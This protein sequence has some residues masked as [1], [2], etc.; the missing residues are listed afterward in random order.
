M[1]K[2]IS[3]LRSAEERFRALLNKRDEINA[4]A[5]ATRAERDTLNDRKKELQEQM[6]D[7]RDKRDA[8][9]A[10]MR[11]FKVRRDEFQRKAKELIAFK[12]SLRGRPLGDLN[13]EIRNLSREIGKMDTHQ[14]TVPMTIP[15]E[16]ALL[17][18]MRVKMRELERVKEIL[19]EQEKIKKEISS[20][21]QSI[22]ELFKRADQEHAEVVR[23]SEE[24]QKFHEQATAVMKDVAA[25]KASADKKHAD[26][27]KLRQEADAVHEKAS[28]M[29]G[30]IIEIR[31]EKRAA[32][33]EERNAVN[34]V[35]LATRKALDDR[36]KKDKAA[37]EALE[38]LLK[39]GK[40]QIR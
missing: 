10:E 23:L 24:S 7:L 21:D 4:T 39:K 29:R 12:Q 2:K 26:Y 20:V 36:E 38:L 40:I 19:S 3:E 33:Q 15:K 9:V 28:E 6:R 14:Q 5:A 27:M 13:E 22:D 37:D 34:E 25:L 1:P 18:E 30:R 16:R 31:K 11:A 32:W 35:N 8:L 17:D